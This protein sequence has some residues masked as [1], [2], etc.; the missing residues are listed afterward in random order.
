MVLGACTGHVANTLQRS[1]VSSWL[2]WT[3][4]SPFILSWLPQK[5][6]YNVCDPDFNEFNFE[7]LKSLCLSHHADFQAPESSWEF[8]PNT[9]KELYQLFTQLPFFHLSH[10]SLHWACF[11]HS[12]LSLYLCLS[13][14]HSSSPK[15]ENLAASWQWSIGFPSLFLELASL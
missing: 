6:Y 5:Q 15:S 7:P 2:T 10:S 11:L 12:S 1:T 13:H 4:F 8:Y 14:T 9:L 3:C